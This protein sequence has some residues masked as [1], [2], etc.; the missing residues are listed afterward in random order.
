MAKKP[1]KRTPMIA[2]IVHLQSTRCLVPMSVWDLFEHHREEPS[3]IRVQ[4]ILNWFLIKGR[5]GHHS[6]PC[7]I[8]LLDGWICSGVVPANIQLLN[9]AV[10]CYWDV[11]FIK[12]TTK[13]YG[14]CK[15]QWQL[16]RF[17]R[18]PHIPV[19]LMPGEINKSIN[20]IF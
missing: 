19:L 7:R 16:K 15:E 6:V 17:P 8:S 9:M 10:D 18:D 12:Q 3:G 11:C 20:K 2:D 4:L 1:L 13:E 5:W 14:S